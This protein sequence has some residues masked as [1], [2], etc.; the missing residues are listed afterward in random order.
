MAQHL[1]DIYKVLRLY[2]M[3]CTATDVLGCM[4]YYPV[5]RVTILCCLLVCLYCGPV[6]D[7]F[8]HPY[9]F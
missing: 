6:A 9:V 4:V 7:F 2:K 1:G 3:L 8:Y 5:N